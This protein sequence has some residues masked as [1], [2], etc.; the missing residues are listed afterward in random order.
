[1][2]LASLL[3]NMPDLLERTLEQHRPDDRGR[4][5]ACRGAGSDDA[6]PWPCLAHDLA[7]QAHALT[8]PDV[9]PG[10]HAL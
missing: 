5:L 4:C 10:R 3:A 9:S 8:R 2:T 1:M 6:A 7:E